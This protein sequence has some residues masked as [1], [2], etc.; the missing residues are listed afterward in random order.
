[1]SS[2]IYR[3]WRHISL[4]RR[5]Q[6]IVI[7]ILTILASFA[8]VISIGAALP[9]IA[10][11]TSPEL[12]INNEYAQP[13]LLYF[14]ITKPE[15]ILFPITLLFILA[16]V[17]SGTIRLLLLWSQNRLGHAIGSDIS[18][19]IY[20]RTL[21]QQYKV[22]ISTNS[23]K[24]IS[25]IAAKTN[26]VVYTT[27]MPILS[28][29]SSILIS[30]SIF[31]ILSL[32]NPSIAL[33]AFLSF[34]TLYLF[35][36][37]VM[38]RR[39]NFYGEQINAMQTKI[40]KLLQ[41]GLG[42]IRDILMDDAQQM[43]WKAYQQTDRPMRRFAS[44]IQVFSAAPRFI[45]ESMGLVLIALLAYFLVQSSTDNSLIIA[46][47]GALAVGAQ[48]LLP[49][50]Q[51]AYA[52]WSSIIGGKGILSSVLELLE[53]PLP[54]KEYDKKIL[55]F[56]DKIIF[57]NIRFQYS[58]SA[59]ITLSNIALEIKKGSCIGLIGETGSGKSTFLDIL[60][61]LLLPSEG[62][63][64][65]D[66]VIIDNDNYIN[67]QAN[68]AHVPQNIFLSDSSILE[69]I[70]FGSNL[71]DIDH[72]RVKNACKIANIDNIISSWSDGYNSRVGER[73]VKISG[74]QKQRIGIAR[75][76]YKNASVLVL[77]EA[78]SALDNETE[79]EVMTSI[80]QL[81]SDLTIIMVA[82]RLS[83]LKNCSHIIKLD[84][85]KISKIGSYEELIN[86]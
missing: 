24:A 37:L 65:I 3:L 81:S 53:Q 55:P 2:L 57:Q 16:A 71:E 26:Q 32:I 27:I 1:M 82:H 7:F 33:V 79:T 52:S 62:S 4:K 15:Q 83:S 25:G 34:S 59:P 20:K 85:G 9:F 70:A 43:Y 21:H 12:I 42:N 17:M 6:F 36:S 51:L 73:G 46:M 48:R 41:E 49:V 22:H 75:A 76:I 60:M 54:V 69:N 40:F 31:F 78:T 38:R 29:I 80:N 74:G 19:D 28:L 5:K 68:I 10:A 44:N 63:I 11:I 56:K 50:L 8:E 47:L 72:E 86:I 64:I 23:S 77:D 14:Q 61:G 18:V 35:I 45:I 66:D 84:K 30:I 67:W 39:L 58:K 13:Y